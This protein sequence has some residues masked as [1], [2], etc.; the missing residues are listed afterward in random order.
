MEGQIEDEDF[1]MPVILHK[2]LTHIFDSVPEYTFVPI[3]TSPGK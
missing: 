1:V 3:M 2:G